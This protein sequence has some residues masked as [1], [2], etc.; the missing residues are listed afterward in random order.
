MEHA[1]L[2][3]STDGVRA[4]HLRL[5]LAES[6]RSYQNHAE[7]LLEHINSPERRKPD[8][9]ERAQTSVTR[10]Q[11]DD[12]WE[13]EED[14]AAVRRALNAAAEAMA[15]GAGMAP[16]VLV[17]EATKGPRAGELR[18]NWQKTIIDVAATGKVCISL[19]FF[20]VHPSLTYTK[21]A[22]CLNRGS[23]KTQP[24]RPR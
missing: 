4:S 6:S 16:R 14:D 22:F 13:D 23:E 9:L 12:E 8:A 3:V 21:A 18:C 20:S 7:D 5:A 1:A 10:A 19:L 2:E 17:V 11:D 15:L 24:E